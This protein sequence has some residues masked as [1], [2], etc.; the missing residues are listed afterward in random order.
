MLLHNTFRIPEY[1]G[2]QV[3]RHGR[4]GVLQLG[5]GRV[6]KLERAALRWL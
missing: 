5:L 1:G 2:P 6:S 4:I 3:L